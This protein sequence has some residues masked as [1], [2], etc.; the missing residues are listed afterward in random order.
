MIR[1]KNIALVID[2]NIL[3]DILDTVGSNNLHT[4]LE[5]WALGILNNMAK[6]PKGKKITV[7]ASTDTIHDY[8]TGL[9]KANHKVVSKTIKTI[10]DQSIS[11][12]TTISRH[13]RI[14]MSLRKIHIAKNE[15]RRVRD[16]NDESFL[17][18]CEAVAKHGSRHDFEVLFASRDTRTLSDISDAFLLSTRKKLPAAHNLASF[19]ELIAC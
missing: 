13:H 2:T 12:I 18:L 9:S 6:H 5:E 7:F 8:K 1:K 14:D 17:L 11:R 15:P 3:G 19:E 10:F 4:A 16:R